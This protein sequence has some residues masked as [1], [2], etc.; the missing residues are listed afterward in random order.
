MTQFS[1]T[2]ASAAPGGTD[3]PN[4]IGGLIADVLRTVLFGK[5]G[6]NGFDGS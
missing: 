5:P 4:P 6:S 1:G 2:I 3:G